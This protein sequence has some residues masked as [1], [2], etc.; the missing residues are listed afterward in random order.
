MHKIILFG[1]FALAVA[2]QACQP[3]STAQETEESTGVDPN[4]VVLEDALHFYVIGDW[5][6]SG[7]YMQKELAD[8][9]NEVA[10]TLEPEFIISTGDNFYPNG[11]ASTQ[12]P[13]WERSF[14]DVYDGHLLQVPWHVILGNHDIRGNAQAQIDYSDISRRWTMP[15]RY[16]AWEWYNDDDDSRT[17]FVFLDTNPFEHDYFEKEKYAAQVMVL[18]TTA[19]LHWMDS[20][21][22]ASDADWKIVV[23]HHPLYTGGKRAEEYNTQRQHLEGRM[24]QGGVQFYLAGHEH[25]LQH[26]K[27]EGVTHHIVSGAGSEVRPTGK[28]PETVFAEAVHGFV[29]FSITKTQ[30]MMQF[31]NYRGEV[32]YSESFAPLGG[33]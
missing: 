15:S 9:M 21:L 33:E 3:A 32:I 30:T 4:L 27:P 17:Q 10:A 28:L 2:L 31:I 8:K 16:F 24:Q 7:E 11:V 20:I 14:E 23:G 12:D 13:L 25:D 26:I 19:Q 18:D 1:A 5:G 29:A 22:A 6:R